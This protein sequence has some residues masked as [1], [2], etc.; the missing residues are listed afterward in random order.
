MPVRVG[1]DLVAVDSVQA[2]IDRHGDRYLERVYT[3]REL[4][5]CRTAA[6][7][8]AGRLA[9][10]FAAKEAAVKAL[11]PR[12]RDALPWTELEVRRTPDGSWTIA[13]TGTAARLAA[14]AGLGELAVSLTRESGYA[15][16]VVVARFPA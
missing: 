6:G 3:P 14:E 4:D 8:A 5:A 7:P 15:L 16:A 13:L 11:R 1:I 10:C 9:G 12:E 2:A